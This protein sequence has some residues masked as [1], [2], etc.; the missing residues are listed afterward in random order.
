LPFFALFLA[1]CGR[2]FATEAGSP[3]ECN[4]TPTV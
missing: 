4:I 3:S 2:I 1:G